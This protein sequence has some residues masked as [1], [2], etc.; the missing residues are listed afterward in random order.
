[1][2]STSTIMDGM[3]LVSIQES[4]IRIGHPGAKGRMELNTLSLGCPR[5]MSPKIKQ[6]PIIK[7][8]LQEDLTSTLNRKSSKRNEAPKLPKSPPKPE[9]PNHKTV[10][11]LKPQKTPSKITLKLMPCMPLELD[12]GAQ[13]NQSRTIPPR[14]LLAFEI[15]LVAH[16]QPCRFM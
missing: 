14:K 10:D 4:G 13:T 2:L 8:S 9:P 7:S 16:R 11:L 1:M 6:H 15:V 12:P 5:F 3:M